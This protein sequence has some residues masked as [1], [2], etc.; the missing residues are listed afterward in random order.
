MGR[1]GF[2]VDGGRQPD[3]RVVNAGP[4]SVPQSHAANHLHG[5]LW[6]VP[7]GPPHQGW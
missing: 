5:A 4:G 1:S 2:E 3:R 6:E 7:G